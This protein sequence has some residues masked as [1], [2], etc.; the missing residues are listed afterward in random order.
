[1]PIFKPFRGTHYTSDI[2]IETVISPPYDVVTRNE[3]DEIASR[4]EAN[5]MKIE[6][7]IS[8]SDERNNYEEAKFLINSWID[9]HILETD[10]I[11]CYYA[12]QMT[13][14]T[15]DH[16]RRRTLGILGALKVEEPGHG[17][18][19]PHENTLPKAKTDRLDLLKA[20]RA[21]ISPIWGLSLA[22]G[23]TSL[24]K[25][26]STPMF[27]VSDDSSVLHEVW[28]IED[29]N[30]IELIS[31]RIDDAQI[32]IADGHHRYETAWNYAQ[33][34]HD[35]GNDI[36]SQFV[37]TYI[38]ELS[39]DQLNVNPIHRNISTSLGEE[40]LLDHF[41]KNY[42]MEKIDGAT[43]EKFRKNPN[44]LL[45]SEHQSLFVLSNQAWLIEPK[46]KL[47]TLANS[48]LDYRILTH[49][50][51]GLEDIQITYEHI[52][53]RAL[54]AVGKNNV[55]AAVIMKPVSIDQIKA[56]CQARFRMPPK[57]TFFAPKPRTGLVI[58][59]L[60]KQ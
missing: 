29:S 51:E 15:S 5:S 45:N 23:L 12:Y 53:E 1:M 21:N 60:D 31:K 2:A 44:S 22:K 55:R 14:T 16:E 24:I 27:S 59:L 6:L 54:N 42:V 49:A 30:T 25:T 18:I 56:S 52:G 3:R 7:P 57:S 11:E 46:E 26:N 43:L 39:E 41:G 10:N 37:L 35:K 32:L 4:H 48:D 50:L 19:L 28:K 17:S 9:K 20:T 8:T 47:K 38:V 40:D 36:E 34:Q 33:I 58:R 13:F